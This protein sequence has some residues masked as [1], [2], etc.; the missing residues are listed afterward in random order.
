MTATAA[1]PTA[2]Q[3][4]LQQLSSVTSLHG[5]KDLAALLSAAATGP[6][7]ILYSSV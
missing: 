2:A 4:A 7:G 3:A 1:A 6:G 5:L